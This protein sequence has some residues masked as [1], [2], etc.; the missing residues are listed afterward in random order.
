VNIA[1]S[2]SAGVDLVAG[3]HELGRGGAVIA[4]VDLIAGHHK[5]G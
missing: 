5:L 2:A 4:D 1:G 3:H